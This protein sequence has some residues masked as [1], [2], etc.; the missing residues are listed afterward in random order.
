M[1][2]IK[3]V[4]DSTAYI[5]EDI[6]KAK[7]IDVLKLSY[8]LDGERE[9]EGLPGTFVGYFKKLKDSDSFP[10]T[11][12]PPVGDFKRVFKKALDEGKEVIGI[13]LSSEISGAYSTAVMA[14]NMFDT[15]KITV[16]DSLSAVG[17][18]KNMVLTA[19][20]MAEED[21]SRDDIVK[22]ILEYKNRIGIS[23][24]VGNL[25]YLHKGGRLSTAKAKIGNILNLKPVLKM[26]DGLLKLD[27]TFRGS[28]RAFNYMINKIPEDVKKVTISHVV[29]KEKVTQFIEIFNQK[30]PK[31]EIE[32]DEVG[33]IIGSHLG[34]DSFGFCY[35]Y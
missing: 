6:L 13:F 9:S 25:D 34:P 8:E 14:A 5:G 3:I 26:E 7:D 23:F 11:S 12:Q 22:E 18:L 10:K 21:H 20:K 33:P 16:I 15:D 27:K 2:K 31:A 19:F 1:T 35:K 24:T 4:T 30:F 29:C 32:I 28:K 17:H